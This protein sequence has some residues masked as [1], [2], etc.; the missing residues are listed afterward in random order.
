MRG[1]WA[2][3]VVFCLGLSLA[4]ATTLAQGADSDGDGVPDATDCRPADPLTWSVPGPATAVT[5]GGPGRGEISWSP[6]SEPG[7]T[8]PLYDVLRSVAPG[9]FGGAACV[10]RNV[11]GPAVVDDAVPALAFYYLV[12]AKTACGGTL[13]AGSAGAPRAGTSCSGLPGEPCSADAMC[14]TTWCV[15]GVCC[16]NACAGTCERCDV[17]PVGACSPEAAGTDPDDEC[18]AEPAATCGRTGECSGEGTCALH[19]NGTTCGAAT[20]ASSSV[21]NLP[22]TCGANGLCTD[23]GTQG[24]APYTCDA[25]SGLC[26]TTCGTAADCQA[27]YGCY[28]GACKRLGG[29]A[30]LIDAECGSGFCTDGVCCE[31]RCLGTCESCGQSNRLGFCDPYASGTDPAN[32]C[33]AQPAST[34]GTSGTC[35]GSRSCSLYPSGTTCAAATCLN[36]GTSAPADTCNGSGTCVDTGTL[37]CAPYTCNAASGLCK[38]TCG[39]AADCQAGYTCSGGVCK[40]A[41]G[42]GCTADSE[43]GSGFCTDG[44]CCES[45]CLGTCESCGQSGRFGFCDPFPS[46]T[47]PANECAAQPASTCGTSGTCSGSRSCSLYPSGTTCAAAACTGATT[48]N[49]ADTCNGSGTCVDT[50]T[51]NCAPYTCNAAS[52]LCKTTCGT[53]ADCQ[54]GYTCSGG[55][56]KRATGSGCTADS[57]CGSGFCTDGVCCESRCLG[58]CESCGQSGRFGFC[59]P[60]P[61]GTDPANECAAQPA[62]TCGTS[63]TCS[64]SRS[65][66][67]YPSGTTCAAAA[68]TGATTSNPADTCNG[69][70]TCVDSGTRE[71][72]PYAC[73]AATGGCWTSCASNAECAPGHFCLGSICR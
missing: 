21:S 49:P 47:D 23:G 8:A 25:A 28:G 41:T 57:E 24:C 14:A 67:L 39:T 2:G 27:G 9:D 32:E 19:P 59:D 17:A 6:P 16:E 15:D 56:C 7:S 52:G 70:G 31:S 60:F 35:S 55:V 10:A 4:P 37:N 34:C 26:K 69:S 53:A 5:V 29:G 61:S 3:A 44:V 71:C 20:C 54:A 72:T 40:R 12:R 50:G 63:G 48:S 62:S 30:C 58:T 1:V 36:G 66:S 65:C 11:A 51:L 43:C 42:S 73:R 38:T 64:G 45:R 33:A 18:A 13:G 68:C 22:D 46:G